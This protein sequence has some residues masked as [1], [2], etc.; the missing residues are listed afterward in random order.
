VLSI[1]DVKSVSDLKEK[2]LSWA[3]RRTMDFPDVKVTNLTSSFEDG[4]AVLALLH[5]A[6]PVNAP[7]R[8]TSDALLN[9]KKVIKKKKTNNNKNKEMMK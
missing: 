8:P 1:P 7:Y 2:I 3:K 5:D 4:R 9:R 6:D